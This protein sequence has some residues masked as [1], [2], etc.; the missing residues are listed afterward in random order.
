MTGRLSFAIWSIPA[1]LSTLETVVFARQ[2][3]HPIP[4]WRAFVSEAPQWYAWAAFTPAI[5]RLAERFP[6][7]R[8]EKRGNFLVHAGASLAASLIAAAADAFVGAL[9]R[10]SSRSLAASASSWFIGQLPATTL[11]YFAVVII[12]HALASQARLREREQQAL[13]LETQLRDAQLATLRMQFQ[14]HF[15]F[16]ALNA[17]MGL[18]R[19]QRGDD[20]IR[21]LA[22]LG[23]VFRVAMSA[24]GRHET[25][26]AEELDFLTRY[27]EIE[28]M[29]F[30]DRLAV[31]IHIPP[32]LS[33]ARVPRFIL[34]PFVE[35]ALKHGILRE[36]AGNSV[37][38]AASRV[39]ATLRL[40]VR[41]DGRG[42]TA[43]A[44]AGLGIAN[45]RSR[46]ER[47]YGSSASVLV[48]NAESGPGVAV[49]IVI[50]WMPPAAAPG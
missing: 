20:A 6:L 48:A 36:R 15:L 27:L 29:R 47:M 14:P 18:V 37:T 1:L 28:R 39:D 42:L 4:V 19:D 30:G 38:I 26:L 35:N 3:G 25:T 34:Q 50:P 13:E 16:N 40:S 7:G 9:V 5:L 46:L 17:V 33:R 43:P 2:A 23:D 41:D 21:A 31:A 45:A 32:E 24:D 10:P 11:A 12:G 49:D 44:I 8:R 22:L